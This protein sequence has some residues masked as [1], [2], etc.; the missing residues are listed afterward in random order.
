M[1]FCRHILSREW[2][3]EGVCGEPRTFLMGCGGGARRG[4]PG[5]RL[6]SRGGRNPRAQRLKLGRHAMSVLLVY[7]RLAANTGFCFKVFA[8]EKF[9]VARRP[10]TETLR[11]A[12]PTGGWTANSSHPQMTPV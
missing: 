9:M 6:R 11:A 7:E 2:G 10:E 8:A 3:H 5:C 1:G 12:P 4:G